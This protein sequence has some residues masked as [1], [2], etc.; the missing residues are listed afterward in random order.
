MADRRRQTQWTDTLVNVSIADG[1]RNVVDL[2]GGLTADETRHWTLIRTIFDLYMGSNTVA[3]AWGTL[4]ADIGI[5]VASREA[6]EAV[7]LADPDVVDDRPARGWIYRTRCA[8][9]QNGVGHLLY[10]RCTGDMRV[11]RRIDDGVLFLHSAVN[12]LTGT[13]FTVQQFGIV[14]ALWLLP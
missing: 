13:T 2:M 1:A 8:V 12:L 11:G 9:T 3:G 6:F 5:G 14:R 10:Q 7:I 4:I